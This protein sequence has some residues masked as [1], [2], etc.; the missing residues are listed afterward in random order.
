MLRWTIEG[1]GRRVAL[2]GTYTL[3]GTTL[4]FDEWYVIHR[5]PAGPY[6]AFREVVTFDGWIRQVTWRGIQR[7]RISDAQ[8]DAEEHLKQME[9]AR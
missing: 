3:R 7:G 2:V 1:A 9:A 8:H 5:T 6:E 4:S